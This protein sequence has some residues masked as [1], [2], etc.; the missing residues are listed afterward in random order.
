MIVGSACFVE[1][2]DALHYDEENDS[3]GE[4]VD[5]SAI[6]RLALLDFGCHVGLGAAV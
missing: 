2:E 4:H 6:V 5:L 3:Y 1:G